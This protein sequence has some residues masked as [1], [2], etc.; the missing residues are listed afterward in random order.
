MLCLSF[1]L[2]EGRKQEKY[3]SVLFV[4]HSVYTILGKTRK[5]FS[6][7]LEKTRNSRKKTR[8]NRAKIGESSGFLY[9]IN[10]Q[11]RDN[12]QNFYKYSYKKILQF[13]FD[14]DI[15]TRLDMR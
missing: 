13:E 10:K 5:I 6:L 14:Y 11:M 8:K 15:I 4:M 12:S 7:I 9:I 2:A 3:L 1:L